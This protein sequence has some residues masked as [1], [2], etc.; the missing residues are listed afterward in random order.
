MLILAPENLLNAVLFVINF[1][2]YV[3]IWYSC[4]CSYVCARVQI[5]MNVCACG[6]LRCL[7]LPILFIETG[8]LNPEFIITVS[9]ASQ[10]V[11]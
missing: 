10:L 8:C 1:F 9:L 4:M 3:Y 7:S 6:D 5:Y 11:L 2:V